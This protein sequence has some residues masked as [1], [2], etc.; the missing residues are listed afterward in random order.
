MKSDFILH[1]SDHSSITFYLL[2]ILDLPGDLVLERRHGDVTLLGILGRG[3]GAAAVRRRRERV[4]EDLL[5]VRLL[6]L[7]NRRLGRRRFVGGGL[8][9]RDR[10]RFIRGRRLGGSFN[11]RDRLHRRL[12]RLG[13]GLLRLL[14]HDL[15]IAGGGGV[16]A[17]RGLR[18]RRGVGRSGGGR[19]GRRLRSIARRVRSGR[20]LTR[21][22]GGGFAGLRRGGG[23]V[24]I[25]PRG[26]VRR[27][28]RGGR[29]LHVVQDR[30]AD[31]AADAA[32]VRRRQ[33]TT[34]DLLLQ[35]DRLHELGVQVRGAIEFPL[36]HPT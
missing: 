15:V 3:L 32:V 16:V 7:L 2:L 6:A 25:V 35:L 19:L 10:D 31:E 17:L 21:R 34:R 12:G 1:P 20:R 24:R 33:L 29:R 4:G 13:G 18:S 9:R 11:R 27:R 8:G 14:A 36:G 22:R 26:G 30:A 5:R 28:D 23:V